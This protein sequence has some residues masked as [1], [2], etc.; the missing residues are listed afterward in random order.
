MIESRQTPPTAVA[1][2]DDET[3]WIRFAAVNVPWM[4]VWDFIQ[5]GLLLPAHVTLA[6]AVALTEAAGWW[7]LG[8]IQLAVGLAAL[9]GRSW[10]RWV[11]LALIVATV[12]AHVYAA[13]GD[14]WWIAFTIGWSA[15]IVYALTVRW[16]RA[17]ST[18]RDRIGRSLK[19]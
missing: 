19:A 5:G 4:A 6:A 10:A 15:V 7:L 3:A 9:R 18:V 8:M 17:E 12:P 1:P 16:R 14:V 2:A 13:R 11:A